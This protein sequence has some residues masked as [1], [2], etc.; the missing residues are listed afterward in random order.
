M[1]TNEIYVILSVML[2]LVNLGVLAAVWLL[3]TKGGKRNARDVEEHLN[4]WEARMMDEFSRSRSDHNQ[5]FKQLRQELHHIVTTSS[6]STLKRMTE[7]SALQN[8]QFEN[9]RKT[10]ETK[11]RQL[12]EDNNKKLEEM[13]LTVD[14]KLHTTLE[15]RLGEAFK[16]VGD[17][18]EM[19]HKGLGEMQKLA[20]GVG[21]LKN[22]LTNVKTRGTLGEIQLEAQLAQ[23]LSPQQFEKN[24]KTKEGSNAFV[25]FAIKLPGKDDTHEYV[26]LPV[27]SKFPLEQYDLLLKAYDDGNKE[28]ID[29]ISKRL[30]SDIKL[31]AKDIRTKYLDPPGTTDFAL[32]YLPIEGLY[33]EVLRFS[34]LFE[35]LQREHRVVPVGPTTLAAIL[36][37]LQMGFRTLAI[38]KRT[39][40]V[41]KLLGAVKTQ[42]GKFGDL[43]D[44]TRKKLDEAG[45][46]IDDATRKTRHIE[47]RLSKVQELPETDA[48]KL[49]E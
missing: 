13:R 5:S 40:E 14:E 4:R 29:K 9:I 11:L 46:S 48:D 25:E 7:I 36:N 8:R 16:Q 6:D 30:A 32:M 23:I 43:L 33:A 15:K 18:L 44:K 12:Q 45:K 22:V 27:D 47:G 3:W 24:V 39:S 34:G 1:M 26:W 49:I 37:S 17:R 20:I 19:V 21:D 38:E 28:T 35:S 10:V 2:L 31:F 41:W 42:F